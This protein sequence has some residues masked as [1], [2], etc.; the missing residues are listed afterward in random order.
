[1]F[2]VAGDSI[3]MEKIKNNFLS[4]LHSFRACAIISIVAGHAVSGMF[5]AVYRKY[6]W[7]DPILIVNELF[8]NQCTLYFALISGLLFTSVLSGKS[9]KKFYSG[10]FLYVFLPY[11]FFTLFYSIVKFQRYNLIYVDTDRMDVVYQ[12]LFNNLLFGGGNFVLWYMP[13]LFGLYLLTP[14]FY[15]LLNDKKYGSIFIWTIIL[16]PLVSSCIRIPM[17]YGLVL[18]KIIYFS[19]AYVLGMYWGTNMQASFDWLKEHLFGILIAALVSTVILSFLHVYEINAWNGIYLQDSFY[20]IQKICLAVMLILFFKSLGEKQPAWLT[21]I[22][23]YSTPIYF[24]H[25]A[26]V[27]SCASLFLFAGT[28]KMHASFYIVGGAVALTIFTIMLSM[29]IAFGITKIAGKQSRMI[30]GA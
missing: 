23:T 17:I 15:L 10:R 27:F 7:S 28:D 30:I 13:V 8:F 29:F 6:N 20:Y 9:Y 19:G 26:I 21:S 18:S 25:G 5:I 11:L 22:G 4:Y 3:N 24:I 2:H 1:M 14:L 16:L 12:N